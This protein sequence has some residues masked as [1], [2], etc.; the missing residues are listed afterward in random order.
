MLALIFVAG[1]LQSQQ[2]SQ[3]KQQQRE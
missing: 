3:S 2:V 1:G